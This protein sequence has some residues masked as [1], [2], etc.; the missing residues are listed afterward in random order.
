MKDGRSLVR[1]AARQIAKREDESGVKPTSV[2]QNQTSDGII[3][4]SDLAKQ[5]EDSQIED[6]EGQAAVDYLR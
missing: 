4:A 3:T 5:L 6:S 1:T 2:A